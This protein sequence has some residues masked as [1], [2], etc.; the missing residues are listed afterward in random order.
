MSKR[1]CWEEPARKCTRNI[2]P[3]S[4]RWAGESPSKTARSPEARSRNVRY[5]TVLVNFETH[6][7]VVRARRKEVKE[8]CW[9]VEINQHVDT[10][11]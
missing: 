7:Y 3:V 10:Q 5:G 11:G 4:K 9:M 2:W 6:N 1:V 8:R